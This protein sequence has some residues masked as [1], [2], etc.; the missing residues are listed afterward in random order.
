M[1]ENIF[2]EQ[3]RTQHETF[4]YSGSQRR[5]WYAH[6]TM[7]SIDVHHKGMTHERVFVLFHAAY[8][9]THI[10]FICDSYLIL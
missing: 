5:C 8:S 7:V 1:L 2:E 6:S 10:S 4:V 9:R 3:S